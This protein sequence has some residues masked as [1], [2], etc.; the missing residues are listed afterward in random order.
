MEEIFI[1]VKIDFLWYSKDSSE[2]CRMSACTTENF[3]G[4]MECI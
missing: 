2:Q 3:L 4:C 1:F